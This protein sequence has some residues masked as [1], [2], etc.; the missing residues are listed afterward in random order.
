MLH[1]HKEGF[2]KDKTK[3]KMSGVE[4]RGEIGYDDLN[5]REKN[6]I[7]DALRRG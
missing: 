5:V 2:M 3:T 4:V 6:A 7:T 1:N